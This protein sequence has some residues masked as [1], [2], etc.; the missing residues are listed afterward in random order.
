MSS[1]KS[2]LVVDDD[3]MVRDYVTDLLD[4]VGVPDVREAENGREARKMLN[5]NAI[6][7]VFLDINMAQEN[8]LE[9]LKKVRTGRTS[10]PRNL[11]IILMTANRAPTTIHAASALDCNAYL[12]KPASV[13]EVA[14]KM[15][16]ALRDQGSARP[17]PEYEKV[18]LPSVDGLPINVSIF[19]KVADWIS[20]QPKKK[21]MHEEE[22]AYPPFRDFETVMPSQDKSTTSRPVRDLQISVHN[23]APGDVLLDNVYSESGQ[24]VHTAGTRLT[25]MYIDNLMNLSGSNGFWTLKVQRGH[26]QGRRRLG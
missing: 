5:S 2:V 24:L 18:K 1:A 16:K 19:R 23:L 8:G 13:K 17:I 11:P 6:D 21:P 10:A 3:P 7:L 14:H 20:D 9:F 4:I 25:G 26:E 15:L 12:S 22:A